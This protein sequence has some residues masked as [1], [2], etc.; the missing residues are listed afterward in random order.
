M[1]GIIYTHFGSSL[2]NACSRY[3]AYVIESSAVAKCDRRLEVELLAVRRD[4]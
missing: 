3:S 4:I 1:P 2:L